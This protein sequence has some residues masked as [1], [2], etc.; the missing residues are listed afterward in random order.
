ML[1]CPCIQGPNSVWYMD[2]YH[3]L[4]RSR[5]TIHTCID[6]YVWEFV[7]LRGYCNRAAC[8]VYACSDFHGEFCGLNFCLQSMI[9]ELWYY[10]NK[11]AV[12]TGDYMFC[13]CVCRAMCGCR[14]M[15]VWGWGWVMD[16]CGCMCVYTCL[17]Y[18]KGCPTIEVL[19]G[20]W[21]LPD[22][23]CTNG[24]EARTWWSVV[25]RTVI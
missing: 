11:V 25:W 12:H 3:K 4:S 10:M 5:L 1:F 19:L 13:L 7:W 15:S 2:G 21:E 18:T 17:L 6:G 24:L 14:S 22:S 8:F 16:G 23:N 9:H 20:D